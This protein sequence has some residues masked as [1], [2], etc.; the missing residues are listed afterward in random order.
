M[1]VFHSLLFSIIKTYAGQGLEHLDSNNF[2]FEYLE[3]YPLT[4]LQNC[5]LS[6][7]LIKYHVCT[8][9]TLIYLSPSHEL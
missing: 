6:V 3:T 9:N 8:D 7:I 4:Y 2:N 1:G 5:M